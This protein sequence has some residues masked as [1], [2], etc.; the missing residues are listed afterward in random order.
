MRVSAVVVLILGLV[1]LVF[2][3]V[4]I[5]QAGSAE[6]EIAESIAPLQLD[7]VDSRYEDV[8][9]QQSAMR[10]VEG[11]AIQTGADP[12]A[13]YNYLTIQRTSLGLTRSQIGLASVTRTSGIINI[14]VG[15]GLILAGVGLFKKS[16]SA[17]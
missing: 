15:L 3:I 7:D 13:M 1:A 5:T 17:A 14:I 16:Q 4:F 6:D 9:A 2:G 8:K 11:P 12:S 10:M